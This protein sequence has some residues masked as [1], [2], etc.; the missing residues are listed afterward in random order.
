MVRP[1]GLE[2]HP[3]LAEL[4]QTYDRVGSTTPAQ[5]VDGLTFL[6]GLYLALSPWIVGFQRFSGLAVSNLIVGLSV[7]ALALACASA[8]GRTY[9]ISWL[10]PLLGIWTLVSPWLVRGGRTLTPGTTPGMPGT[11][12]LPGR[13]ASALT[14]GTIWNNVA[15]GVIILLLGAA[16]LAMALAFRGGQGR[17]ERGERAGHRPGSW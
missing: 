9:G 8:F 14:A 10:L 4:R 16:A 11:P 15:T 1:T 6:S 3:D 2:H 5:I 17:G 7:A 12:G 13:A